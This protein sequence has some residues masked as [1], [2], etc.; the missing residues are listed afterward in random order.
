MSGL[1][2][3]SVSYRNGEQHFGCDPWTGIGLP[4]YDEE[5]RKV[6]V[7]VCKFVPALYVD[8]EEVS[9]LAFNSRVQL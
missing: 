5:E 2:W 3:D 8:G 4:S 9:P 7:E 6:R 1:D